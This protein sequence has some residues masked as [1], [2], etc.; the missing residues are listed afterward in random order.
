[1]PLPSAS[2]LLPC[3][4]DG[5]TILSTGAEKAGF[6]KALPSGRMPRIDHVGF[7]L[8]LGEDGKKIATRSGEVSFAIKHALERFIIKKSFDIVKWEALNC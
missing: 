5:D 7:G 4:F 3:T 6:I 1:M 2:L 8:V